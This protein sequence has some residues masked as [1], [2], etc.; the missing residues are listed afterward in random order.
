MPGKRGDAGN[1]CPD[2]SPEEPEQPY[3]QARGNVK[4]DAGGA[5]AREMGKPF[6]AEKAQGDR[7]KNDSDPTRRDQMIRVAFYDTREYDK[8]SFEHHGGRHN[9]QFRFLET[10][11]TEDTVELARGCDAVCVFVNDTVNAAVIDRLAELG[12]RLVALRCAGYNNVDV[13]SAFG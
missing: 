7:M 4:T 5:G 1:L 8:P 11:L 9:I 6:P 13:H 2:M 3:R 12:V 10:R